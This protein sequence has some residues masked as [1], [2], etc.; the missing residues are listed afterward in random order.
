MNI[1]EKYM[2]QVVEELKKISDKLDRLI[3]LK[4]KQLEEDEDTY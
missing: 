1:G 3:E 2:A 4:E